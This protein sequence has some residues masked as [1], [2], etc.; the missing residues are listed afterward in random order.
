[1]GLLLGAIWSPCGG[2]TLGVALGLAAE[3]GTALRAAALMAL[4]GLGSAAPLVALAYGAREA[5]M[6]R[7]GELSLGAS[8]A[9]L[10]FGVLLLTVGVLVLTGTDKLIETKLTEAMPGWLQDLTTR[11]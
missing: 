2:P 7:R 4:F 8:R 11:F 3:R 1:M 10:A 9:K 5:F 6:K